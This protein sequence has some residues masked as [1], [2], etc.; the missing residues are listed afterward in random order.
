MLA[1]R[2][3]ALAA[4][5]ALGAAAAC[6][7]Q[8]PPPQA[9]PKAAR[10]VSAPPAPRVVWQE[11]FNQPRVDWLDP[12]GHSAAQIARVYTVEHGWLHALH[13][14]AEADAVPAIDFG[15]PFPDHP[16]PLEKIRALRWKWRVLR[17]PTTGDDPW[18]D[19]AASVYVV[20]KTP[21]LLFG[22]RGFK[23][24][25]LARPGAR[26][27]H[28]HGLLQIALRAAPPTREWQSE[29]VDLCA[30][31]RAGY[32]A[33]EG[34]HLLYVGVVT[35]ADNTHSIAEADYTD[36]ELSAVP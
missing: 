10:V 19:V 1:C 8:T 4:V 29:S 2:F 32:G 25:W 24:G 16:P 7:A 6:A 33:C 15:K 14:G 22:G 21:S 11:H 34:Q 20:V 30:L 18:L 26:G 36:F 27:T 23:F 17:H 3:V 12:F 35:D 13:D 5:A 9:T 31:Y 28:Q